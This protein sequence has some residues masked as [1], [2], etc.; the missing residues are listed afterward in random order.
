M[1]PPQAEAWREFRAELPW[2][3]SS[4]RALVQLASVLRSRIDSDPAIGITALSAYSAVLSKLAATPVD[5][6]RVSI[7]DDAEADET[8]RFFN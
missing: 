2:L 4:H 5:D 8:A 3:T 6:S 1:T 7:P